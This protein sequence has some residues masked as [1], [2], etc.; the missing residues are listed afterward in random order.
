MPRPNFLL[1]VY[2]ARSGSTFL[3]SRVAQE[4]PSVIVLPELEFPVHLLYCDTP[5]ERL[6][7]MALD[8]R[9]A[10]LNI[11]WERLKRLAEDPANESL[12]SFLT[13]LA[14]EYRKSVN[15]GL[16][17]VAP[18]SILLK[19]GKYINAHAGVLSKSFGSY[20]WLSISRDPRACL[21]SAWNTTSIFKY[22]KMS[23]S[24]PLRACIRYRRFMRMITSLDEERTC[25]IRYEDLIGDYGQTIDGVLS[26]AGVERSPQSTIAYKI[27]RQMSAHSR[28]HEAPEQT[29]VYGWEDE[30]PLRHRFIIEASLPDLCNDRQIANAL[31]K[32][33]QWR[34]WAIS[35]IEYLL[36]DPY[37]FLASRLVTKEHSAHG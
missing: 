34:F 22:R 17:H 3:A 8:G 19:H 12:C 10:S 37:H 9:T 15:P 33:H 36:L 11:S 14:I 5:Q 25:S 27:G 16:S 35:C 28:I 20:K 21:S 31:P 1:L 2:Y 32:M 23:N 30:L 13:E 29:R 7:Q 18:H 26:F 24:G 6:K 4:A